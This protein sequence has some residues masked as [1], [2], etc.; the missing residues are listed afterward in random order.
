MTPQVEKDVPPPK[1]DPHVRYT[2]PRKFPWT[3]M[4]VGDSFVVD[5]LM[6]A[7][8]ASNSFKNH[9]RTKYTRLDPSYRAVFRKQPDGRYRLWLLDRKQKSTDQ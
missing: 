5:T 2:M 6:Q 4:S 9:Q 8:S 1:T 3:E 7:R